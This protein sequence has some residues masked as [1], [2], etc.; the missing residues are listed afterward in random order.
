MYYG[1]PYHY[2]P[3]WENDTRLSLTQEQLFHFFD[4]QHTNT[5]MTVLK[6][7]YSLQ[8]KNL[9][10]ADGLPMTALRMTVL[11]LNLLTISLFVIDDRTQKSFLELIFKKKFSIS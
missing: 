4:I 3:C 1:L 8:L 9:N 7:Q 2:S 11:H 10:M 5:L 6:F